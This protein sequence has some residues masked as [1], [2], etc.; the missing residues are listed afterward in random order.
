M[1][2]VNID[3]AECKEI[4]SKLVSVSG[5]LDSIR[6][7][8]NNNAL[9][10]CR[11]YGTG[12]YV[13]SSMW[14]NS[15]S[16]R[17]RKCIK[18]IRCSVEAYQD[19]ENKTELID[20]NE[21]LE[22]NTKKYQKSKVSYQEASR[23]R[24]KLADL[25]KKLNP[26]IWKRIDVS[27]VETIGFSANYK[28]ADRLY[29][30][31]ITLITVATQ[32]KIKNGDNV[33]IEYDIDDIV[34]R[35]ISQVDSIS[36]DLAGY[37]YEITEEGVVLNI[38]TKILRDKKGN[39]YPTNISVVI[40][41]MITNPIVKIVTTLNDNSEVETTIKLDTLRRAQVN[42][43]V[44]EKEPDFGQRLNEVYQYVKDGI[45]QSRDDLV[46]AIM[47]LG[48]VFITYEAAVVIA[49]ILVGLGVVVVVSPVP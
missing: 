13:R 32:V 45:Y 27:D 16:N 6:N 2:S 15:A 10:L 41:P 24:S 18:V 21:T 14:I 25:R 37:E 42:Q 3:T 29:L 4:L 48:L 22:N 1:G 8:I 47:A 26:K 44:E 49:N 12:Y 43:P 28:S 35:Q 23:N 39:E 11:M 34:D 33:N 20:W 7:Q 31:G 36:I 5:R 17:L 40:G 38:G 46:D 30:Y 19:A 9:S